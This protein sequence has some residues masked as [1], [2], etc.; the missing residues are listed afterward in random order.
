[1]SARARGLMTSCGCGALAGLL[2]W[3]LSGLP[4]FGAYHRLYG[5]YLDAHAVAQRHATNVVAAVTFDYRGVDT[6]IEEFILFAAVVGV[7]LLLRAQRE[8]TEVG[9]RDEARG[10]RA[11]RSSD[12]VR[13]FGL[14]AV[15]PSVLVG[16][17]IVAHG[18]LTPGGGFQGGTVLAG[19]LT[20]V[21]L[22]GEYL[23]FRRVGPVELMDLSEGA[24]AAAFVAAG[25]AGLVAAGTFLLNL[26]PLGTIGE[27]DSAGL[28]PI[29]NTAVG[30]EVAAGMSLVLSEFLEQTLM[31]RG[32]RS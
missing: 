16:I 10:R 17:Y 31:V 7:A 5:L 21:Y 26:L 15:G 27:I 6:M 1:M 11:P 14:G 2:V 3:A 22:A 12:A 24:A 30:V 29:V 13:M 8:E 28:I 20:L 4:D 32:R 18:H 23:V 9:P 25:L 19:A